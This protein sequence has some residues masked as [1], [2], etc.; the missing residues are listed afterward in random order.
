LGKEHLAP[1]GEFY[2]TPYKRPLWSVSL[3][4]IEDDEDEKPPDNQIPDLDEQ[5]TPE[6]DDQYF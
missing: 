5:V 2:V 4:E 1:S 6:S 3:S